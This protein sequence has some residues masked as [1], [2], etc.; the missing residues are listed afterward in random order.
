MD[1]V[2][3]EDGG[4]ILNAPSS[5]PHATSSSSATQSHSHHGCSLFSEDGD[6]VTKGDL[7]VHTCHVI[8]MVTKVYLVVKNANG[9]PPAVDICDE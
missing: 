4:T 8:E 5:P 7:V 6:R 2:G 9:L 3:G 1:G